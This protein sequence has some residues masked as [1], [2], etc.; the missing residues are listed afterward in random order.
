MPLISYLFIC[1]KKQEVRF[2]GIASQI[3]L[4]L[5]M[6]EKVRPSKKKKKKERKK[7]KLVFRPCF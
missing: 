7:K 1:R 6:P 5:D 2:Y 4:L 3:K